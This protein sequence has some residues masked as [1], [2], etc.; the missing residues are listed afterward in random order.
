MRVSPAA[1]LFFCARTCDEVAMRRV[2][3]LLCAL[4]SLAG[5]HP[6]ADPPT[7]PANAAALE[8]SL[9]NQANMLEAQADAA[10]DRNA[11][12]VPAGNADLATN[13]ADLTPPR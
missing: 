3:L 12:D 10:A 11:T 8:A 2:S 4:A 7:P 5:C 6:A 1:G 13:G 9:E